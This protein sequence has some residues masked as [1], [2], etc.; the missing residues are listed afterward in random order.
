M[1]GLNLAY[2]DFER[3]LTPKTTAKRSHVKLV[4]SNFGRLYAG[5]SDFTSGKGLCISFKMWLVGVS[6]GCW[7]QV[8]PQ[9]GDRDKLRTALISSLSLALTFVTI[10]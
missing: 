2:S 6:C 1:S 5:P 7:L 9:L 8:T 4:G 10:K 3:P